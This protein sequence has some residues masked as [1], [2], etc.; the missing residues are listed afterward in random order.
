MEL[1]IVINSTTLYLFPCFERIEGDT[2][3]NGVS[4]LVQKCDVCNYD[5]LCCATVF[6]VN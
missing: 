6:E 5:Q 1:S 3:M 2:K 4:Q